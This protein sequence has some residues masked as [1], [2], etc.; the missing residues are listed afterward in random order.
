MTTREADKI[1]KNKRFV[2]I[3]NLRYGEEFVALFTRRDRHNIYSR[4]GGKYDRGELDVVE[5]L[6]SPRTV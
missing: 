3:R 4:T 1:I 5:V 6:G 2:L